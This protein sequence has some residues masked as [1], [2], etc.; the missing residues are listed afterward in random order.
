MNSR[1]LTRAFLLSPFL[2]AVSSVL[3]TRIFSQH[4]LSEGLAVLA[5][6]CGL[7]LWRADR[8]TDRLIPVGA[9]LGMGG[10]V[11]KGVFVWLGIRAEVH[12]MSTHETTPG[13]P[14]LLHIHHLF[15]NIGFLFYIAAAIRAGIK[16]IKGIAQS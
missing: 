16:K 13:N 5:F 1:T 7:A 12:D 14:L 2:L 6:L 4:A 8:S 9:T 11:L 10:L 15:F 3:A